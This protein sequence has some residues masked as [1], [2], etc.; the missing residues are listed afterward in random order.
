MVS[1]LTNLMTLIQRL[2][3]MMVYSLQAEVPKV[4]GLKI[5]PKPKG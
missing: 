2:R 1:L 3:L 5:L 4:E